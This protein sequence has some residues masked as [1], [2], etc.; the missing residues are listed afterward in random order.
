MGACRHSIEYFASFAELFI[1]RQRA[2]F[3]CRISF[4]ALAKGLF[5]G[6]LG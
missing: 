6:Y 1:S 3:A 4:S 2:H 5:A